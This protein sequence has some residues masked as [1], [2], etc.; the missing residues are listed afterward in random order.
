MLLQTLHD[1]P[2]LTRE[3]L[4]SWSCNEIDYS[5]V[6]FLRR[7]YKMSLQAWSGMYEKESGSFPYLHDLFL[8]IVL[9]YSC[10]KLAPDTVMEEYVYCL[11][12]E[13]LV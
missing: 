2:D 6:D 4:L 3:N 12:A 5:L 13:R 11:A 7:L 9:K 1:D 8:S 10:C